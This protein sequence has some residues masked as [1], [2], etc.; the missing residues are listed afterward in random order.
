MPKTAG[1]IHWDYFLLLED[2]LAD[3]FKY[4]EPS[5]RNDA[6]YGAKLAKLFLSTCSEVD[7]ALKDLVE[8]RCRSN[9]AAKKSLTICDYRQFVQR[10]F[11]DEFRNSSVTF[12]RTEYVLRPWGEWWDGTDPSDENP[13]WWAAYNRVKHH[14]SKH[15]DEANLG[16]LVNSFAGLFVVDTCLF[17]E[18]VRNGGPKEL[19]STDMTEFVNDGGALGS[20]S[21]T[22]FNDGCL[23]FHGGF[24]AV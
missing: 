1:Q 14:R 6:A 4:L 17:R 3:V 15:Y 13:S 23:V 5:P 20:N 10:E 8:L 2:D 24:H 16:N 7:V 19:H 22:E 21:F 11:A 12:T 18:E 9:S